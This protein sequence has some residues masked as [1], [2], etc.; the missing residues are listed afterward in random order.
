MTSF[1]L[2]LVTK[3]S[4]GVLVPFY[5]MFQVLG[6][7]GFDW[8]RQKFTSGRIELVLFV[9]HLLLGFHFATAYS[10]D[11]L[12]LPYSRVLSLGLNS[13]EYF[14]V[15]FVEILLLVN[16]VKR[17]TF[18][19]IL[20]K[21]HRVDA[22]LG[23]FVRIEHTKHFVVLS[24]YLAMNFIYITLDSYYY[25]DSVLRILASYYIDWF[26]ALNSFQLVGIIYLIFTRF[27]AYN[28]VFE[29]VEGPETV[30]IF[31]QIQPLMSDLLE[32]VQLTNEAFAI[33][34]VSTMSSFCV[35]LIFEGFALF[36]ALWLGNEQFVEFATYLWMYNLIEKSILILVCLLSSLIL[37][38]VSKTCRTEPFA[39]S[40]ICCRLTS[41]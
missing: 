24:S 19:K 30:K 33:R 11:S 18:W 41:P 9:L 29:D 17:K 32:L 37:R 31:K 22:Q 21:F 39:S 16:F 35:S 2:W 38:E 5:W 26:Y 6:L 8:R 7:A 27:K 40:P 25:F 12:S 20:R 14:P 13:L 36:E 15:M 28:E 1:K 4:V 3:I 10:N 23:K 34:M